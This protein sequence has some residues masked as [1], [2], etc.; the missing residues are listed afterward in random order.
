MTG[1]RQVESSRQVVSTHLQNNDF[2]S[3]WVDCRGW[4][5]VEFW[6]I[7][8]SIV[9]PWSATMTLQAA[10]R[11]D[12]SYLI[13]VPVVGGSYGSWPSATHLEPAVVVVDNPLAIMR[14]TASG[15]AGATDDGQN[16]HVVAVLTR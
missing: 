3:V 4:K 9:A 10:L 1:F 13:D 8:V 16:I 15:V 5:R 12:G 11:E 2:S 6:L 14:I 7:N